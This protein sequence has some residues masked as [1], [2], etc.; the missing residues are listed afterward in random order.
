MRARYSVIF[1]NYHKHFQFCDLAILRA[2]PE[3][4]LPESAEHK[5]LLRKSD[6]EDDLE[7]FKVARLIY[8]SMNH[9]GIGIRL[10]QDPNLVAR[11]RTAMAL[12]GAQTQHLQSQPQ[13]GTEYCKIQL[14]AIP[15]F[16]YTE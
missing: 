10:T 16:K 14:L 15:T 13:R 12:R 7:P 2:R 8:K 9:D 6:R 11:Y 3:L 4:P 1:R 5:L